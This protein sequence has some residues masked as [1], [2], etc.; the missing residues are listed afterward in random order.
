MDKNMEKIILF[1][2]HTDAGL[3]KNNGDGGLKV[4]QNWR[5]GLYQR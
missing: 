1:R 5:R 2:F 4:Y 3:C